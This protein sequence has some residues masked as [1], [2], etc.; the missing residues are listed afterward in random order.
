MN[1]LLNAFIALLLTACSFQVMGR[2]MQSPNV[3]DGM[4]KVSI[5]SIKDG[6]YQ[7][8][9][10][11]NIP[12]SI[13]QDSAIIYNFEKFVIPVLEFNNI[14]PDNVSLTM[15][16]NRDSNNGSLLSVCINA[17]RCK[18]VSDKYS[19]I[20]LTLA[21]SKVSITKL[22][23]YTLLVEDGKDN[24]CIEKNN[25]YETVYYQ[26]YGAA[27]DS[28]EIRLVLDGYRA[29]SFQIDIFGVW[30]LPPFCN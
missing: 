28:I 22:G 20:G 6:G 21:T 30:Y 4:V 14:N 7:K 25:D 13:V 9:R 29:I 2:S 11:V 12:K 3:K 10:S 23:N 16:L 24:D 8:V 15:S 19:D 27:E 5:D 17:L 1:K 26:I 18:T